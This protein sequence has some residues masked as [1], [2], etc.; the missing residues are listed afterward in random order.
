MLRALGLVLDLEF[1]AAALDAV[2]DTPGLRVIVQWTPTTEAASGVETLPNRTPLTRCLATSGRFATQTRN[3]NGPL[4]G[5]ALRLSDDRFRLV[6]TDVNGG[7]LKALN[8]TASLATLG[9]ADPS[10]DH[11]EIDE[12]GSPRLRLG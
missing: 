2:S 3:T 5:R 12:D 4:A 11:D 7:A 6:Q 1:D 9:D 8:F 10:L